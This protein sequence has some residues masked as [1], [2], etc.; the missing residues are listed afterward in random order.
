M[1]ERGR[2]TRR[3]I[4]DAALELFAPGRS[5]KSISL[6]EVAGAAGIVPT[7]FYRHF[8]SMDQLALAL[9]DDCGRTLRIQLRRMR[10]QNHGSKH[11]IRDSFLLFRDYVEAHPKYFAVVSGERHGGSPLVREAIR[12]EI[13]RFIE[14]MAEDISALSLLPNLSWHTLLNVCDLVVNTILSAASEILDWP[15]GSERLRKK[16]SE[17]YV[18]QLHILFFGAAS[19]RERR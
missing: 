7:A 19:W 14:E 13:E 3:A 17:A 10:L 16:R 18:Q 6:R 2:R 1:T 9:V 5:F 12:T 8:R 4:M 11:L 15:K